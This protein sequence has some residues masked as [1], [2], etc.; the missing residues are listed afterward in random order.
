VEY[1]LLLKDGPSNLQDNLIPQFV[2]WNAFGGT[3][4][5]L[6]V[7]GSSI[8]SPGISGYGG[9]FVLQMELG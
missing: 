2:R 6:N 7:D 5:I 8:G 1:A 3:D 4:M 9:C